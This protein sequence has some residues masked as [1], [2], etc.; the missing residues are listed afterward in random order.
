MS[1]DASGFDLAPGETL[2]PGSVQT[3]SNGGGQLAAPASSSDAPAKPM[4]KKPAGKKPAKKPAKKAA[5]AAEEAVPP[6]PAPDA[7][8]DA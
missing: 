1:A 7:K 6:A 5:D 8:T 3:V 2:V 4:K